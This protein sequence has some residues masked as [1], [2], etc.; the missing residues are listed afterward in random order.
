VRVNV[1]SNN[2]RLF[3]VVNGARI[4]LE[5]AIADVKSTQNFWHKV[6]VETQ[7]SVIKCYFDGKLVFE[8]ADTTFVRGGIGLWTKSDSVTLFDDLLAES[9]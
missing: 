7:G 4:Q 6:G 8:K 2:I 3:R 1:N 5:G 9:L